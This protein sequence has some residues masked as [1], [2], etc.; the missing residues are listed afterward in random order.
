MPA[1]PTGGCGA[2]AGLRRAKV[3]AKLSVMM[4]S[5]ALMNLASSLSVKPAAAPVAL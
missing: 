2:A 5:S 1:A 3:S 4:R